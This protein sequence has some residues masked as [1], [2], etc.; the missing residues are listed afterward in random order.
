MFM[1]NVM[2]RF[3]A[4]GLWNKEYTFMRS[5]FP[6]DKFV[7]IEENPEPCRCVMTDNIGLLANGDMVACCLDYEGEMKLGN[8]NDT[9]VDELFYSDRMARI[10]ENAALESVCRR[11]K[12]TI[13]VLDTDR[14]DKKVQKVDKFGQGWHDYE[15]GMYGIGGR[16]TKSAAN[17]YVFTRIDAERLKIKYRSEQDQTSIRLEIHSYREDTQTFKE[18]GSFSLHGEKGTVAELEIA[19]RF[20]VSTFYKIVLKTKTFIPDEVYGNRD[21][22]RLGVAVFNISMSEPF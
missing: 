13:F 10:R 5:V 16:W 1:P 19:F 22:R 11:C 20:L 14:I 18:E 9:K 15:K 17:S 8:I 21:T 7:Y 4:L 12:G 2:L 6:P 3:K